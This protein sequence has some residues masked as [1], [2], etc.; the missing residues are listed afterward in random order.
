MFQI[1]KKSFSTYNLTD[2]KG[3]NVALRPFLANTFAPNYK[4]HENKTFTSDDGMC[5]Y[6]VML[7]K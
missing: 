4:K 1:K 7:K 5:R 3:Q 6:C 2:E